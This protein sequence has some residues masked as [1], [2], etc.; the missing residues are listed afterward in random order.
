[1]LSKTH[2]QYLV[3]TRWMTNKLILIQHLTCLVYST[4]YVN[5]I[6]Q[7][8]FL[9]IKILIMNGLSPCAHTIFWDFFN[10]LKKL[11]IYHRTP[12]SYLVTNLNSS[13][14]KKHWNIITPFK[15]TILLSQSS[16]F[17]S[18]APPF[19]WFKK[20][21]MYLPRSSKWTTIS[22]RWF[23][24]FTYSLLFLWSIIY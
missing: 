20:I 13:L 14:T 16:Y 18:H 6:S 5:C 8:F 9:E 24:I 15:K 2:I 23:T 11:N 10:R 7:A 22:R 1:M 17:A 3:R 19:G 4:L 21:D 12:S